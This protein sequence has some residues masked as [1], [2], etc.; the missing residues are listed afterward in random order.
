M[1]AS[2]SRKAP[3][4]KDSIRQAICAFANDLPGHNKPGVV[5]VGVRDDGSPSGLPVTDELLR[6]LADMKS[7]GQVLPPPSMTVERLRLNGGELA[8]IQVLPSDSPPVRSNSV[9]RIRTGT[10]R[11][12][13]SAQDERILNERRRFRDRPFDLEPVPAATLDDLNMIQF[14]Q[15]Y[16]VHAFSAEA[17][18]A[19]NRTMEECLAATKMVASAAELQPTILG[20]LVLGKDPQDILPGAYVQFIRFSGSKLTDDV[21][22]S[23]DLTGN[24]VDVLRRLDEKLL[25]HNRIAVDIVLRSPGTT[26]RVLSSACSAATDTECSHA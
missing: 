23:S 14:E 17:L 21:L 5:F 16:L 20:V 6:E 11:D 8:V 7:D 15:E 10:R 22:D 13:A 2:N 18:E 12:V 1:T 25:S 9:V 4:A 3:A 19:N 26:N 24:V